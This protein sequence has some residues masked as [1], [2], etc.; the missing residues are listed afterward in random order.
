LLAINVSEEEAVT[1]PNHAAQHLLWV[2]QLCYTVYIS[3]MGGVFLPAARS[4]ADMAND[5]LAFHHVYA[6]IV[7]M[8]VYLHQG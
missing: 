4:P 3:A 8:L 2:E 7:L 5:C 1:V 6:L